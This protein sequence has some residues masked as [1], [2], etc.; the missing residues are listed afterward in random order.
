MININKQIYIYT[1]RLFEKFYAS[2]RSWW[3]RSVLEMPILFSSWSNIIVLEILAD[4]YQ[5]KTFR[6]GS[7]FWVRLMTFWANL[8]YIYIYIYIYICVCMCVCVCVCV[9]VCAY[10]CVC[11]CVCVC[12]YVCA[13]V[14]AQICISICDFQTLAYTHSLHI[15]YIYMHM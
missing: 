7:S 12:V 6:Y 3:V 14:L 8:L 13:C 4:R 2:Q 15:L 9:C 11:V 1:R 10:A 5:L